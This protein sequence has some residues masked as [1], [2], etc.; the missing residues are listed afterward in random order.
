MNKKALT[1]LLARLQE[2]S[3]WAAIAGAGLL[4]LLGLDGKITTE[5]GDMSVAAGVALAALL[6]FVL[7]VEAPAPPVP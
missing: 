7:G 4:S 5:M 6:S 1:W 3:S 2:P